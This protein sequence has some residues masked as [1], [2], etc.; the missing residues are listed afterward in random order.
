MKVWLAFSFLPSGPLP[1]LQ[2]AGGFASSR[3]NWL[4]G[5]EQ[6]CHTEANALKM[7]DAPQRRLSWTNL[8][9]D[10]DPFSSGCGASALAKSCRNA[11]SQLRRRPGENIALFRESSPARI[12][13]RTPRANKLDGLLFVLTS[14]LLQG[15]SEPEPSPPRVPLEFVPSHEHRQRAAG[16]HDLCRL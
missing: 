9:R 12:S 11:S 10:A 16:S 6:R 7:V 5:R 3:A 2:S 14:T 15:A 4:I 8:N 1:S 13:C